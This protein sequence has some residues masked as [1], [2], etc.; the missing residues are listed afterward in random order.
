VFQLIFDYEPFWY[1]T[2]RTLSGAVYGDADIMEVL[3]T[4][5]RIADGDGDSWYA[6]WTATAERLAAEAETTI[7][8]RHAV[9]ARLTLLR[10]SNYF[11]T[12]EFFLHA[13]PS[14]PRVDHA[15]KY[16]VRC[17][18]MAAELFHPA[19]EPIEIPYESSH[20]PGYFYR[21]DESG[22]ARPL[23][24]I[25]SGV[26]GT[27]EECRSHGAAAALE[28]GYHVIAFD[29]PG[30]GR[31]IY[32]LGFTFRPDWENVIGPVVDFAV[33]QPDVDESRIALLGLSMGG[34]LAP[35]AAAY[36]PRL[37]ALIAMDGVYELIGNQWVAALAEQLPAIAASRDPRAE[38]SARLRADCDP[39]L[40]EC[41]ARMQRSNPMA[42]W[43]FDH[44]LWVFGSTTLRE[45]QAKG[46]DYTL[47]GGIAEK[48]A[49]PALVV[50]GADDLAFAGQP[51]ALFQHLSCDKTFVEFTEEEG[52]SAHNQVGAL[53]LAHGRIFDWLDDILCPEQPES[54]Q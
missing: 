2:L 37:A 42:K 14:D 29:G 25:H 5:R 23:L 52:A 51:E 49:C 50:A 45:M 12:A 35:R 26:D 4:A 24:L 20:L 41:L 53:A 43:A 18:H 15:R 40:D 44:A 21:I 33:R 13:N 16:S 19:I 28:R 22:A 1:Q 39:E 46:L 9:T 31:A 10:A 30:Q 54:R 3:S 8:R 7:A 32:E 11:R 6:E 48:I 34:Q 27:A 17:F 47:A 36:E 38:L